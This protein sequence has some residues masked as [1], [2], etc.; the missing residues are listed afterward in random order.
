MASN[1]ARAVE[2]ARRRRLGGLGLDQRE[3]V[4]ALEDQIGLGPVAIAVEGQPGG[5]AQVDPVL[6]N[7]LIQNQILS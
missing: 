7:R 3:A 6:G 1:P 2:E 4:R 5:L